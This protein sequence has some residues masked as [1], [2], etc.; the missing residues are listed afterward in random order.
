MVRHTLKSLGPEGA[1]HPDGERV[2]APALRAGRGVVAADGGRRLRRRPRAGGVARDGRSRR[3]RRW[4]CCTSSRSSPA[5]ATPSSAESLTLRAEVALG[6]LTPDDVA[7]EAVY[8]AGRRR[9]PAHR[10]R[11]R[12]RCE[13]SSR[14]TASCRYEGEVPL[15]RTGGVRLHGAGAAEQR[16]AR[17]PGRARRRRDRVVDVQDFSWF[18]AAVRRTPRIALI[19]VSLATIGATLPASATALPITDG[20][21][22]RHRAAGR[23]GEHLAAVDPGPRQ[24]RAGT[25]AGRADPDAH[26][27]SPGCGWAPTR[28]AR[29]SAR[30]G[31]R[32]RRRPT[33]PTPSAGSTPTSSA[34]TT[35]TPRCR[36]AR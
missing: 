19:I 28:P 21:A 10:R 15:E 5:A 36:T 29:S 7:V 18:G 3:G 17:V 2:R 32:S 20:Q 16:P 12:V 35:R 24:P 8:G 26:R 33:R 34:S 27:A 1:G 4:R 11:D 13:S 31:R 25:G 23:R 14:S 30:P 9:R 6:G 22:P